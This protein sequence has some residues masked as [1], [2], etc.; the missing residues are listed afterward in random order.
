MSK[1]RGYWD[2]MKCPACG[3]KRDIFRS[4][5]VAGREVRSHCLHCRRQVRVLA[6]PIPKEE[7]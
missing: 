7:R 3:G 2:L 5:R 6:G 1:P 4:R